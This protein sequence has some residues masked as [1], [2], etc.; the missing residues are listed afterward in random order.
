[1]KST[2][3]SRVFSFSSPRPAVSPVP[4]PVPSVVPVPTGSSLGA[5]PDKGGSVGAWHSFGSVNVAQ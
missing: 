3:H 4:I 2:D 1:M 5:L